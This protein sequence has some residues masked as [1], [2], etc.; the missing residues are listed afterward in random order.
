MALPISYNLRNLVE[1]KTTTAMTALGIALTSAV[2]MTV[3]AL[4]SGL[5]A[6][7]SGTGD[8]LNIIVLRKGSVAEMTSNVSRQAFQDLLYTPGIAMDASRKRSLASLEIVTVVNLGGDGLKGGSNMNLRGILPEDVGLHD[9][10]LAQGRWFSSGVREVVVGNAVVKRHPD[11]H[12]GS[13]VHLGPYDWKVVGVMDGGRSAANSEIFAD[14]NQVASAFSRPDE[15]TSVLVRASSEAAM[16]GLIAALGQNRRVNVTAQS[17]RAYYASQS[18]SGAPLQFLGTLISVIMA[19]GSTFAA[20]NTMYASV[21]RRSAEIGTLR[22]LGFSRTS[23]LLSFLFES[24]LLASV[25]GMLACIAVFPLNFITTAIGNLKTFTETAFRFQVG[26]E[27]MAAGMLFA[28]II[29]A[30]GGLLPAR[31]AARKEILTALKGA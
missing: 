30:V 17:E 11:F 1:R 24:V 29:G 10:T 8:P 14:L 31:S 27:V 9:V 6:A 28:L 15:L 13:S 4:M 22:T 19:L 26:F 18:V 5:H 12:V 7:L 3:L 20:M 21:A 23:I 2:L 25:A 16:P